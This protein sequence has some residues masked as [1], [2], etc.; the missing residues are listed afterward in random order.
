MTIYKQHEHHYHARVVRDF[1]VLRVLA[2]LMQIFDFD[3]HISIFN[4]LEYFFKVSLALPSAVP[5]QSRPET[6]NRS[7]SHFEQLKLREIGKN[8]REIG[9]KKRCKTA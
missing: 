5:P 3:I 7:F 6:I 2:H 8:N 1:Q 9:E 4:I